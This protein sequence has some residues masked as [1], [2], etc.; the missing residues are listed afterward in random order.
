L[1]SATTIVTKRNIK[2]REKALKLLLSELKRTPAGH[3]KRPFYA[4][5]AREL[6]G[7]IAA[8]KASIH[9]YKPTGQL[10]QDIKDKRGELA[11]L[12]DKVKG[13][14]GQR[15]KALLRKAALVNRALREMIAA[16]QLKQNGVALE[17]PALPTA[18][19]PPVLLP[20]TLDTE[21][22]VEP[23]DFGALDSGDDETP[24]EEK[25]FPEV[26]DLTV[27]EGGLSSMREDLESEI[28]EIADK[29][30]EIQLP[31]E[32]GDVPFYRHPLVAFGLGV[33]L[34]GVLFR[35]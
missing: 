12:L 14:R 16:A 29:L 35:N 1:S 23:T 32:Y 28:N 6:M 4:K 21:S 25:A 18:P 10:S 17:A 19:P 33:V 20:Q 15:K 24:D 5:K 22:S 11:R 7:E 13:A 30:D 34:G 31:G 26:P 9:Y 27:I 2:A 8:L 3:E